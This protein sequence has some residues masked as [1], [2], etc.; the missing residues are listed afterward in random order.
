MANGKSN[1]KE[2]RGV[3]NMISNI[4][5]NTTN[6]CYIGQNGLYQSNGN[7]KSNATPQKKKN[8]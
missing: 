8:L 4:M 7:A 3:G 2:S 6:A 5:S 1:D